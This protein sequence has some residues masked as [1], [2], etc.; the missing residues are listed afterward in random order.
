MI[1]FQRLGALVWKEILQISRD[2]SSILIAFLLPLILLFIFGYG[3]SL[4]SRDVSVGLVVMEESAEAGSF[5]ASLKGSPYLNLETGRTYRELEPRLVAGELRGIIV[6]R[7]DFHRKLKQ[8]GPAAPVQV[9]TDGSN[10]NQAAFVEAY[11][12]G[13]WSHWQEMR[14]L[15]RGDPNVRPIRIEPRFW[16]VRVQKDW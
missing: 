15:S 7:E 13:A 2:P 16:Y 8:P 11:V 12:R 9:L 3:V 5:A 4:D 1:S 6:L 10:P 14:S